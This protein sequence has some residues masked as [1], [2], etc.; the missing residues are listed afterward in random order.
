MAEYSFSAEATSSAPPDVVFALLADATVWK[1]W[2]GPLI[3][4][5]FWERE[6]T[7][8]PGGVGAIK[9]LGAKPAYSREETVEY[10]P[11]KRYSYTILSGQPVRTYRADVELT[12]VDGGTHIRWAGRF[13]P[14]IA[15]TGPFMRWYLGRIVAGFAKRLAAYAG[16]R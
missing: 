8:P 9:R 4:E 15:G 5:S 12:L 1:D 10:E 3:R 2:A 14:K 16:T 7:P 6:G 11:P 13:E